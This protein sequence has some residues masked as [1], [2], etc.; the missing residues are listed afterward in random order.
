MNL[1]QFLKPD[2]RKIVIF[3]LFFIF[4]FSLE[5]ICLPKLEYKMGR[6]VEVEL[7]YPCGFLS[8]IID[9]EMYFYVLRGE[10]WLFNY[11]HLFLDLIISYLISC[12]IVWIY[13]KVK[14][15]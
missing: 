11:F 15:K 8:Q 7:Y 2:W 4:I 9:Y 12:L 3:V 14:K 13:D 1:K 6:I 10:S 5:F